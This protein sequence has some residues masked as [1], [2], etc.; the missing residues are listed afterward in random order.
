LPRDGAPI[1]ADA[2]IP[3]KRWAVLA[4]WSVSVARIKVFDGTQPVLTQV[5]PMVP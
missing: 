4:W 3:E 5:P 1:R 2:E